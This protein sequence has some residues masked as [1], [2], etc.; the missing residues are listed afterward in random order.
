MDCA[1]NALIG[2]EKILCYSGVDISGFSHDI[3]Q[4]EE[5]I[6]D[7]KCISA[8]IDMTKYINNKT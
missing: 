2:Y 7:L 6:Y 4:N 5:F 3:L 8:E 1:K